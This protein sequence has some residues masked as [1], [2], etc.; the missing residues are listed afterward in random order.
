M[1]N[2]KEE[3]SILRSY[4]QILFLLP[5]KIF[6][7]L[8][9]VILEPAER[10]EPV[11]MTM[12][13]NDPTPGLTSHSPPTPPYTLPEGQAADRHNVVVHWTQGGHSFTS[14]GGRSDEELSETGNQ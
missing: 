7:P 1:A 8:T 10:F 4:S 9:V 3:Q 11:V 14:G 12:T 5:T 2:D 6:I 13:P